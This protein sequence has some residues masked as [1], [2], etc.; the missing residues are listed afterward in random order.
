MPIVETILGGTVIGLLGAA[1]GAGLSRKGLLTR[2]THEL[3]CK[4][5]VQGFII[6]I[7]EMK[8]EIIKEIRNGKSSSGH[9]R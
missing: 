1:A 6:Q 9:E 3:L 5:V 8:T 2:E 4:N 7:E